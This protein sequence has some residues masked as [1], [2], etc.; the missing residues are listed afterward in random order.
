MP[1]GW[2]DRQHARMTPR[3]RWLI[4][5]L[6]CVALLAGCGGRGAVT[7]GADVPAENTVP[8]RV[9]TFNLEYGGTGVDP[10][11]VPKAIKAAGADVVAI[12][13]GYGRL[14]EI[15]REVGWKYYDTR[16]QLIS[17]LPLLSPNSG[18]GDPVYVE[19]QPGKYMAVFDVHLDSTN[20]GPDATKRGMPAARV[21]AREHERVAEITPIAASAQ[22][23]A[24]R[25]VPTLVMGDFNSPSFQDWTEDTVGLRS[26]VIYP[27]RWPVTTILANSGLTDLYRAQYPDPVADQG[28]TWPANRP[29]VAGYNPYRHGD[30]QD[31]IDMIWAGGPIEGKDVQ[32]V[33]EPG[34]SGVDI[35]VDPW[36]SD[37]RAVAASIEVQPAVIGPVIG[38]NTRL[39]EQGD[40][41]EVRWST[42]GAPAG[43]VVLQSDP[44]VTTDVSGT[45]GSFSLGT[46]DVAPGTYSLVM[47][48]SD[49][50]ELAE[51]QVTVVTPGSSP[52]LTTD[53]STYRAGQPIKVTWSG[54]PGNKWDWVG[55]YRRN[56][57]PNTASYL[58][59][60]YTGATVVGDTTLDGSTNA[61]VWPLKPGAYS[62][63]LLIDDSYQKVAQADFNVVAPRG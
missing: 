22:E 7:G 25:G 31:R 40:D 62:V 46:D 34:T 27:L 13:E 4:P 24:S 23:L 2:L 38:T 50:S 14:P 52:V 63:Y 55:I 28:L 32:I 53:K 41:L 6:A 19:V 1:W 9:M 29:F 10:N 37:H 45:W 54:A 56:A 47:K 57:D 39:V 36:P 11:S 51:T 26:H 15:A 60:D 35:V 17:R 30:P 42:G 61:S 21:L 20:Y 18:P 43:S 48:G 44:A 12:E 8:L 59:W 16:T 33:G 58:V 49:G 3:R 5:V